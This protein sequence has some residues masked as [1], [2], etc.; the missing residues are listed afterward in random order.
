MK[1]LTAEDV[2]QALVRIPRALSS[3]SISPYDAAQ[4]SGYFERG[5]IVSEDLIRACLVAEPELVDDWL[6]YS[7]NKRTSSGWFIRPTAGGYEVGC[8]DGLAA[9]DVGLRHSDKLDACAKFIK[10]E[11]EEMRDV[12]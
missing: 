9:P 3:G 5:I 6:A 2:A 12:A 4:K 8:F 10:Y 11:L 1:P 7:E